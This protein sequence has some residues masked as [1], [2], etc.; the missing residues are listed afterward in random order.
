ML[1]LSGNMAEAEIFGQSAPIFEPNIAGK[2]V[3][4]IAVV[5]G[6]WALVE[7]GFRR[8][9]AA[10]TGGDIDSLASRDVRG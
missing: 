8:G 1:G 6:L 7:L 2:A 9:Q 3:A 10:R 4:M 5:I